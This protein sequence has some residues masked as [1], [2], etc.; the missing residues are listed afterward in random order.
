MT[1]KWDILRKIKEN[2]LLE[3][4]DKQLFLKTIMR[5]IA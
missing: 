1:K 3:K 2:L 5:I 4:L